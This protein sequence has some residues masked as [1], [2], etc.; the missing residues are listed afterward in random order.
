MQSKLTLYFTYSAAVLLAAFTT[1]LFLCN[2]AAAKL[3]QPRDPLFGI[4]TDTLFWILGIGAT[5]VLLACIY[6]REPRFKLA[7]F[8]WFAAI[9]VIY[10]VG[11]Q[12]QGAH[13]LSGY[14][15]SLAHA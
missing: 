8:L 2:I 3:V 4:G 7:L 12:W 1:A 15:G 13:N 5:A 6:M 14:T 11:L 9:A 10:R